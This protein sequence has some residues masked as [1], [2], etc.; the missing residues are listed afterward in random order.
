M[1]RQRHRSSVRAVLAATG[2]VL[3]AVAAVLFVSGFVLLS[4]WPPLNEVST[5]ETAAY[6]D[7]QPRDYRFSRER[8][9][10]AVHEVIVGW[11][12]WREVSTQGEVGV[13]VAT[14]TSPF[15]RA[16]S[17]VTVRV[18]ANGDGG[19]IVFVRST[20]RRGPG[21]FGRNARNV[22]RLLGGIDQN[23][24]VEIGPI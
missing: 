1:K 13:V 12:A 5:G 15:G 7:L 11:P 8:V 21:D 2:R 24:G 10:G 3:G 20:G 4:I 18:Q 17:D 14:V 16:V 6:P 9:L 22:R 19:A 23:L